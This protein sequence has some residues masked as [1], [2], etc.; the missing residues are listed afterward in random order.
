M[1]DV[2]ASLREFGG[3]VFR[4]GYAVVVGAIGGVLGVA[5]GVSAAIAKPGRAPFT[6][7]LWIWLPLLAGGSLVAIFRSFHDVRMERDSIR[8]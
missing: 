7:P 1:R 8:A 5:S 4:H 3:K 2:L 6:I